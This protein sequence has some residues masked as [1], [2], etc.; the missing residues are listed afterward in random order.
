SPLRA[1]G[2][3]AAVT[4]RLGNPTLDVSFDSEWPLAVRIPGDTSVAE[5]D[6][7]AA[8]GASFVARRF[9]TSAS[10]RVAAE[11]EGNRFVVLP[12]GTPLA[13]AC[14]ACQVRDLV[15]GSLSLGLAHFVTAPLAISRQDGFAWTVTYRRREQ[16][17][18]ARWSNELRTR[19]ALYARLPGPGGFARHL[20]AARF[21]A[22]ATGGPLADLLK[23]GGVSQSVVGRGFG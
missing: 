23:V 14:S 6:Q 5:R 8:V 22:G 7:N 16:Q 1:A 2:G 12:A 17:G 13:A 21:A 19:L 9:R 3:F 10:L 20:R 11:Y 4:A 15:G 18:T